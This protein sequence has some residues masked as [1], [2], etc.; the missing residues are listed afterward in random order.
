MPRLMPA[1]LPPF[2]GVAVCRAN[3]PWSGG[4]RLRLH[5]IWKAGR[6]RVRGPHAPLTFATLTF[7][8][9]TVA[10]QL[11]YV[12]HTNVIHLAYVWRTVAARLAYSLSRLTTD[13]LTPQTIPLDDPPAAGRSTPLAARYPDAR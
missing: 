4:W 10:A 12:W 6:R 9:H 13:W 1:P 5:T 11:A 2:T 7:T 3:P 8:V